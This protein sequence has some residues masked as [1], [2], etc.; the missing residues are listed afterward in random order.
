MPP[1]IVS[2]D[3]EHLN[4]GDKLIWRFNVEVTHQSIESAGPRMIQG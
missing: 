4:R 2:K 1:G 3:N